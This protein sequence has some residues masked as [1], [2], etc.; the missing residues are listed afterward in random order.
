VAYLTRLGEAMVPDA[1]TAFQDGDLLHV[2]APEDDLPRVELVLSSAPPL[3][4]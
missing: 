2:V 3:I 1:T 4:D